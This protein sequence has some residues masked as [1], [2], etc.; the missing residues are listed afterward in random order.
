[1]NYIS[2]GTTLRSSLKFKVTAAVGAVFVVV[3]SALLLA[4]TR[5]VTSELSMKTYERSQMVSM[6][7]QRS[8]RDAMTKRRQREVAAIVSSVA[9]LPDIKQI[10]IVDTR[11]RVILESRK[12]GHR[13]AGPEVERMIA[14][15]AKRGRAVSEG[16]EGDILRTISPIHNE[17]KCWSCHS[18]SQK[19]LGH[20][21]VDLSTKA[22][23]LALS[24]NR[25]TI[26]ITG[27]VGLAVSVATLL[28]ALSRLVYKPVDRVLA[29]MTRIKE[30]DISFRAD[31]SGGDELRRLS[32]TL[33]AMVTSLQERNAEIVKARERL[34]EARRLATVGL[35]AAGM[36]HEINNPNGAISV[37][38]EGLAKYVPADS[39]GPRLLEIIGRSADRISHLVSELLRFDPK[40]PVKHEPVDINSLVSEAVAST[41]EGFAGPRHEIHLQLNA[42]TTGLVGD[43]GRLAQAII[44]IITNALE[45]MPS[46]GTLTIQTVSDDKEAE[47]VISDTGHGVDENE[48]SLLTDPFFTSKESGKGRGLGLTIASEI[49]SQHGGELTISG[50]LNEGATVRMRMPK[51][52]N[53]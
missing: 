28:F 34:L 44:N 53:E 19:Y 21:L 47:I 18:N 48:L 12:A 35:L 11:G 37:A 42:D 51:Y 33:N 9:E 49:I 4:E 17:R 41:A 23:R 25:E 40:Q 14:A 38:A 13:S 3:Y 32:V 26:I 29:A 50:K 15:A 24:R 2:S 22:D 46:G 31:T 8:L 36:A 16:A 20:L 27:V 52:T 45:A 6:T 43:S 39:P 7:V 1:M 5:L 10:A 30:G